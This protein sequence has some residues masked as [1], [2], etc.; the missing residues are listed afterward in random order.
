MPRPLR[1]EYPGAYYHVMNRGRRR[2]RIFNQ[3]KE[4][5]VFLSILKNTCESCRVI[6]HAYCLMSNHYHLLLQTPLGNLSYFMRQLNGVYAQ[7]FNK[8]NKTEGALFRGRYKSILIQDGVY[9]LHVM[10]YIHFNPVKA[11][12]A[13]GL[14][15][16]PWSSHKNYLKKKDEQWLKVK[17]ILGFLENSGHERFNNYGAYIQAKHLDDYDRLIHTKNHQ[18]VF[19][20]E[21]FMDAVFKQNFERL[22]QLKDI[23]DRRLFLAL[24]VIKLIKN[25]IQKEFKISPGE[26]CGWKR[27]VENIPGQLAIYLIRKNTR[28]TF[29]EIAAEFLQNSDRSAESCYNRFKIKLDERRELKRLVDR[30]STSCSYAG[31]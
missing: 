23:S 12:L 27:G 10:K 1:L 16:Y 29:K 8:L 21:E 17:P 14:H 28:L 18:A 20:N 9:L 26:L 24:P 4:F 5:K 19:G 3:E 2:E 7:T 30:I 25:E 31:T 6:V 13:A 22:N 11:K 15:D